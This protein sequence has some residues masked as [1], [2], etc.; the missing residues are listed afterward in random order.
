MA[1]VPPI[2]LRV[3]NGF[4]ESGQRREPDPDLGGTARLL[5]SEAA[6]CWAGPV[7]LLSPAWLL[8]SHS[9][10]PRGLP[11]KTKQMPLSPVYSHLKEVPTMNMA[12]ARR[13]ARLEPILAAQVAVAVPARTTGI[14]IDELR[15]YPVR[16]P[17]S[18]R[19]WTV[20]RVKT[21]S[22]LA[23]YGECARASSRG[24]GV[25]PQRFWLRRP[26]TSY[27]SSPA[28][29]PLAGAMDMALLDIAGK[30]A[31]APVY[32]L[33]GGP[34][35]SKAR[36]FTSIGG[37]GGAE[38]ARPAREA[39]PRG[40]VPRRGLAC[41]CAGRAQSGTGLPVGTAQ[42]GGGGPFPGGRFRPGRRGPADPR[43]RRQR[44]G[45]HPDPA[46]AV[47]RR[48]LPPSPAWR[49]CARSPMNP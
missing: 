23:G 3:E 13:R 47:V 45:R 35:R 11:H 5:A 41:A 16:E 12:S 30:A 29:S 24:S 4:A 1:I 27:A 49:P 28:D 22:G 14:E 38:T 48:T 21:R 37:A 40:R 33:L 36:V 2:R 44:G 42:A 31:K 39:R 15:L 34:T 10:P 26:A 43:R 46:S 6:T 7:K 19:A 25:R 32:R 18:G 9:L 20:V 17:V 8:S